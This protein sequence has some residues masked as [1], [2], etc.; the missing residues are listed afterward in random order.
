MGEA[1]YSVRS[2]L[3]RA[4]RRDHS[5]ADFLSASVVTT[6][7]LLLRES[8]WAEELRCFSSEEPARS[9]E[10]RPRVGDDDLALLLPPLLLLT[11]GVWYFLA[12]EPLVWCRVDTRSYDCCCCLCLE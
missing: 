5:R 4:L 12:E 7:P 11:T 9:F 10:D 2:C 6:P 3:S 1:G 8:W